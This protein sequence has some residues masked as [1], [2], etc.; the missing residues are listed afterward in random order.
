M[1]EGREGGREGTYLAVRD[2]RLDEGSEEAAKEN[3]VGDRGE[4]ADGEDKE[5]SQQLH[6]GAK[7]WR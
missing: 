1:E 6:R 2:V 7:G 3:E 4:E 5:D